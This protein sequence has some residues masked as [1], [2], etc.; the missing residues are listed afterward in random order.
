MEF[1]FLKQPWCPLLDCEGM[2]YFLWVLC[3]EYCV[4]L[5]ARACEINPIKEL[6]VVCVALY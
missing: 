2:N 4:H 6:M 3:Q 5:H 1:E